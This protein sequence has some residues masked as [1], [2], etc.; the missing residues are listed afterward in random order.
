MIFQK[1][2]EF[3]QYKEKQGEIAP[4]GWEKKAIPFLIQINEDGSFSA[5]ID[6]RAD[7]KDAGKICL[8]PKT[9]GR[10]GKN[11]WQTA[12]LLWDHIGY[13]LGLVTDNENPET[14]EKQH[15]SF[16]QKLNNLPDTVKEDKGIQAVIKFLEKADFSGI[17]EGEHWD[18]LYKKKPNV[19]FQLSSEA[20]SIIANRPLIK[21]YVTESAS[22][23]EGKT[24]EGRCLVTGEIT[25]IARTHPKIKGVYGA[26]TS[27]AA[28]VS[29]NDSAYTSFNKKQN[30]N[31]PVGEYA[32]FAYTTALDYLLK[33]DSIHK[34]Q[35]GSTSTV[36]WAE[37][38]HPIEN[39][40]SHLFSVNSNTEDSPRDMDD[41]R[42]L[43]TAPKTGAKPILNDNTK[44]YVLGLSPNASR[45]S[46]RF[47]HYSTVKEMAERIEHY[48]LD[49]EIQV[50]KNDRPFPTLRQLLSSLGLE[51]KL[52]NVS[53]VL[54]GDFLRAIF[55]GNPYPRSILSTA[56]TRNRAEQTV[57]RYRAALIKAV[58]IRTYDYKDLTM[59]LDKS[60]TDSAY[61]L[62]RLFAIYE[63]TQRL[64]QGK[65][66]LAERYYGGASS[67]PATVFPMLIKLNQAHLSKLEK[68]KPGVATNRK[69]DIGEILDGIE[70]YDKH[71]SLEKQGL[72]SLGYYHQRQATFTKSEKK[73]TEQ[74]Q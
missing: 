11:S 26:Q 23:I 27:G 45:L 69:K 52:D 4:Y 58:L 39:A 16:K 32:A 40:L 51:Y 1:L 31:A 46:V 38:S 14:V 20:T 71:L 72:F 6:T 5:L 24:I 41:I 3:Y 33:K 17:T 9:I 60:R 56:I 35:I 65:S 30:Y 34:L 36:F 53:P 54:I 13:A 59:S 68:E 15:A 55:E 2:L 49:I 42:G 29:F 43:L 21:Q 10:S 22:K 47:W 8:I 63:Y 50:G 25:T 70:N 61:R 18:D 37:K 48:F 44:F 74:G 62:G 57:H 7:S 12:F 28:I 64:A 73:D 66:S 19:T 67:S